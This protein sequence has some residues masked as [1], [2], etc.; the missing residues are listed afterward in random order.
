MGNDL[1]RRGR[2]RPAIGRMESTESADDNGY[3]SRYWRHRDSR[4]PAHAHLIEGSYFPVVNRIL[5]KGTSYAFGVYT[6]RAEGGSSL[7]EGEVELMLHRA[8]TVDDGLGVG[9]PLNERAFGEGEILPIGL[10]AINDRPK[11]DYR[12]SRGYCAIVYPIEGDHRQ[13]FFSSD[14]K[15]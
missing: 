4:D 13:V 15:G 5:L 3:G 1:I 6:D 10:I 7:A 8:T 9:E 14:L 12:C 11:T 2:I